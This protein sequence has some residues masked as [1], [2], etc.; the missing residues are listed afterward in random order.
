MLSM[1]K[2]RRVLVTE[3]PWRG[4]KYAGRSGMRWAHTSQKEPLLS[5][6]PFVFF[7][8]TCAALLEK[9]GHNVIAIDAL[10]EQLDE[11]A[12]FAR[13]KEFNPEFIVA[14]IHTPSYNND[15]Y[16]MKKLKELTGATMIWAGPHPTA[17]PELVI[18]E[19]PESADYVVISEFEY[20][21]LDIVEG[22]AKD[23]IVRP[24]QPRDINEIPWPARH[25]YKMHLYNEVFCRRYPNLQFMAS[26]G[27][28]YRCS[29]CNIHLMSYAE[30]KHRARD[31][32]DVWDE[33]EA[34][35][36]IYNPKEIYFDDDNI[37]A[38]PK[39]FR[40]FLEEKIN[41]GITIPFTCMGH[42]NIRPEMLE[43]MKKANC[44]GWKLGIE[45]A[46]NEVLK[47]LGKFTTREQMIRTIEKCKEL[48]I[49]THLT[50]CIGL[51][52]DT[53]ETIKETMEFAQQYAD[54]YQVSIAA[55][56][57]GT[58]LWE[59]AEREGWLRFKSWDDFDGMQDSIIEYP[60]LP[61]KILKEVAGKG[62]SN[63]YRKVLTTGEW[64]KYVRMIYDEKGM[65]GIAKLIFI[66]GPGMIKD[67][68]DAAVGSQ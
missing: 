65:T 53:E 61:S 63:T 36:K 45:S 64:K 62:Q 7:Q 43:L 12:Y 46:N 15:R 41:R 8:A 38:N 26:R 16:F 14:E 49:K 10:A 13:V 32:K 44:Q 51:P 60:T 17:L 39:W 67:V 22:R 54:H 29:F 66:R 35:V 23:K 42:V 33:V 68:M 3:L 56:L 2:A 25:L 24:A 59:E 37:D 20:P 58:Y 6:R 57:P 11:E 5:F 52:G 28:P 18:K 40:E 9:H 19:N 50:F 30:H 31:V 4:V 34:N 1:S 27:C 47:R 21:S 48:G 55:P